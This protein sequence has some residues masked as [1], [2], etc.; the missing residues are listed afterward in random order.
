MVIYNILWLEDIMRSTAVVFIL[1]LFCSSALAQQAHPVWEFD[2]MIG[3]RFYAGS[4]RSEL[5]DGASIQIGVRNRGDLSVHLM[6]RKNALVFT[7]EK[8]TGKVVEAR[9]VTID[10]NGFPCKPHGRPI[11]FGNDPRFI[12]A[13]KALP[14][15]QLKA[16]ILEALQ[17]LTDAERFSMY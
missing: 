2:P 7:I 13:I 14:D 1:A 8:T 15:P 12:N 5:G 10:D 16:R 9:R 11:N 4:W 17:I 6:N 3:N